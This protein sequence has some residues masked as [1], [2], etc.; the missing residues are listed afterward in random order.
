MNK[1]SCYLTGQEHFGLERE[2][3]TETETET[4]TD[5]ERETTCFK[6]HVRP[7]H[8]ARAIAHARATT[9]ANQEKGGWGR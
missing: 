4:E 9:R 1:E 8:D 6:T 3:E 2:R 7:W 5:R